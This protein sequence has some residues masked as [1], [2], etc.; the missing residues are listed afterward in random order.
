MKT[1]KLYKI[2]EELNIRLDFFPLPL[3]KSVAVS[4]NDRYYIALDPREVTSPARERV[5]L[6]HEL[7]HCETGSFYNAYSPFDVRAKHEQKADKWAIEKLVPLSEL[8]TALKEGY[9]DNA[10]LADHFSV[11]EDFIDKALKYYADK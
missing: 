5:C 1:E 10:A 6:A 3:N 8:K 2:A 9:A 4:L 7:G 11:T